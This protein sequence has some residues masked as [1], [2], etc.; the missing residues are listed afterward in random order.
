MAAPSMCLQKVIAIFRMQ[1]I[2]WQQSTTVSKC[3]LELAAL[4]SAKAAFNENTQS[5]GVERLHDRAAFEQ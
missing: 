3:K 4:Q 1:F 5:G 2:N